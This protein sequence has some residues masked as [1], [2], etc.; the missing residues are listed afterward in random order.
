MKKQR[1]SCILT[2]IGCLLILLIS[3][4]VHA[5]NR[6]SDDNDS[7]DNNHYSYTFE[8]TLLEKALAE[9]LG[10]VPGE[11]ITPD[12]LA[13]LTHLEIPFYDPLV[14]NG[15]YIGAE[16]EALALLAHC[17]NLRVLDL[18]GNKIVDLSPLAGLSQLTDLNL[19]TNR[20][21]DLSPLAK[22][23]SLKRLDL[24]YNRV[25]NLSPLA[26]LPS[27]EWLDLSSNRITD[28]PL[29]PGLVNLQRLDLSKDQLKDLTPLVGMI[30]LK[31][32][33]LQDNQIHDSTPLVRLIQIERLYLHNNMIVDLKPLVD[34]FGLANNTPVHFEGGFEWRADVVTVDNN[35]LSDFSRN[36]YIPALQA[37]GVNVRH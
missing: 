5:P 1:L 25:S 11:E 20:I 34:N 4:C 13:T 18:S 22:L 35:P 9:A 17:V 33:Y 30:Q 7:D 3:A 21:L 19:S 15:P 10:K 24:S 14:A 29:L 37:R 16:A 26:E 31:E 12:E 32:L 28:L 8:Y 2:C 36:V 27:L 23:P 6:D